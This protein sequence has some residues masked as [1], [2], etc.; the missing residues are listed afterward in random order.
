METRNVGRL[1]ADQLSFFER[2]GY[3]PVKEIFLPEDLEPLRNEL[4]AFID[5][6]IVELV[7][8][9]KLKA[10][11]TFPDLDVNTRLARVAEANPEAADAILGALGGKHSIYE[12]EQL[13]R[14]IVHPKLLA[15]VKE[16]IGP[17]IVVSAVTHIRPKLPERESANVP[18]H[19]DSAYFLPHC[20]TELVVTCWLPLVDATVENGCLALAPGLHKNP[21]LPHYRGT[22][23]YLAIREEELPTVVSVPVAM[24]GALFFTSR[25]PHCSTPN[26]SGI[27][28]WSFD[29]RYQPV[30]TPNNT[31]LRPEDYS[32]NLPAANKACW[33]PEAD[34]LISSERT[35]DKVVRTFREF[36]ARKEAYR[37]RFPWDSFVKREWP[38][39]SG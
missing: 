35:P 23:G 2:E 38:A 9:G 36:A 20:D 31:D 28:R 33:P 37:N 5:E 19:Q 18:W 24:G 7:R 10:E 11:D 21:V 1:T 13:F 26:H 25:T 6:R 29:I 30:E 39:A 17:E 3:L 4:A 22:L 8:E 15:V 27:V 32:E 12:G 16:L 34:V 14:V